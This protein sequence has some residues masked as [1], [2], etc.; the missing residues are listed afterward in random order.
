MKEVLMELELL[1]NKME[2]V[3]REFEFEA[4]NEE[5]PFGKVLYAVLNK[6]T[7]TELFEMNNEELIKHIQKIQILES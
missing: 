5:L 2:E 4:G 7:K 3:N 6:T 1:Y